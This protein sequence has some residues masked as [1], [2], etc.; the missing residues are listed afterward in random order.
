MTSPRLDDTM[1]RPREISRRR[2]IQATAWS[3]PIIAAA[4]ALPLA[5]ASGTMVLSVTSGDVA[6]G[7]LSVRFEGVSPGDAVP[8][9]ISVADASAPVTDG[10]VSSLT[11]AGGIAEWSPDNEGTVTPSGLGTSVVNGAA[12]LI[13]NALGTYG[14]FSV[15]V[16]VG[17]Q[18]W[19]LS[20]TIAA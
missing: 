15:T 6:P 2:V 11:G 19:V 10:L 8:L 1:P 13:L 14:T 16:E 9:G 18:S 4:A 17:A 12:T 5:A 3:V 7:T 20:I